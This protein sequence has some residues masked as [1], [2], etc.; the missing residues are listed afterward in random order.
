MDV[1]KGKDKLTPGVLY[2]PPNLR[3]QDTGI[4]GILLQ[5]TGRVNRDKNLCIME[6]FNYRNIDMEGVVVNL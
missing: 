5:E 2:M 1:H 3:G 4:L 6:D